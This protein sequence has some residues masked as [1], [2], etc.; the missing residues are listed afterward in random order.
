MIKNIHASLL[1]FCSDYA[2]SHLNLEVVNFD[3][4]GDETTLPDSDVIGPS[5]MTI[6]VDEEICG[7]SVLIGVSTKE[8]TNL[9]R[10]MEHINELFTAL[11]PTQ[12]IRVYNADTGEA[13]GW[14][15]VTN[16]TRTLA[17]GGTSARPLQFIMVNL[18]STLT[19][20]I[21]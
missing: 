6:S 21:L 13:I 12:R 19:F 17:P 14:M 3:S 5:T 16:G 1:R 9:F 7:I 15:V 4:H 18:L 20:E 11:L 10:M 2:A 8:D